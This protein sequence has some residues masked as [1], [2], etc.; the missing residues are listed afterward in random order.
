MVARMR[1]ARVWPRSSPRNAPRISGL[2]SS[3]AS[4]PARMVYIFG[5]GYVQAFIS[6]A[7]YD[8]KADDHVLTFTGVNQVLNLQPSDAIRRF[9]RYIIH[10]G[11]GPLVVN[12]AS[13]DT[14]EGLASVTLN[15]GDRMVLMPTS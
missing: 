2:E 10:A 15:P 9:P 4:A 7:T 3:D 11:L 5:D 14:V 8:M 13:G 12:P 1:S 6:A